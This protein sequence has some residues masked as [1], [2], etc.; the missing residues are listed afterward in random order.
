M[1]LNET[2]LGIDWGALYQSAKTGGMDLLTKDLPAAAE[3]AVVA[4][5]Q[6]IITPV[7]T[8]LAVEKANKAV[9]KGKV[10]LITGIGGG[11]GLLMGA[12]IAGG[13]WKRRA[14]GGV[15]AGSVL[16]GAGALA[17]FKI[18]LLTD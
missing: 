2:N 10:A 16:A 1:I 6:S 3:R 7:A 5:T 14:V 11:V 15:V 12:L 8:Q 18:G 13:S 17:S 9:N 4:K